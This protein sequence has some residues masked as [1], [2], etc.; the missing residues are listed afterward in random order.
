MNKCDFCIKS[1]S[2]KCTLMA[3]D[4]QF[5]EQWCYVAI[6]TLSKAVEKQRLLESVEPIKEQYDE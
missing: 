2:G 3:A 6:S 5:R 1:I 4:P